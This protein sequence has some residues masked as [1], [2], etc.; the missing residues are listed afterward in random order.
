MAPCR[1][2]ATASSRA[3]MRGTSTT[4]SCC[5]PLRC[6]APPRP[7]RWAC[8]PASSPS[9]PCRCARLACP[10]HPCCAV[11]A[12]CSEQ[13]QRCCRCRSLHVP[14][15][16]LG[17]DSSCS[18]Q[19]LNNMP[20]GCSRH[21]GSN[22]RGFC[23]RACRHSHSAR[24]QAAPASAHPGSAGQLVGGAPCPQPCFACLARPLA[25]FC[26][27]PTACLWMLQGLLHGPP[28]SA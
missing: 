23:K 27:A 18:L 7:C 24:H 25:G 9:L 16:L 15:L 10:R 19:Q 8:V 20:A 26:Y 6:S 11:A 14:S 17:P 28:T 4:H 3:Q 2:R 5:W 22:G 1:W 13:A 21:T 12:A